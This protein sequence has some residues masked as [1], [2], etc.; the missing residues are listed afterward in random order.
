MLVYR[1]V[2][3]KV[4]TGTDTCIFLWRLCLKRLLCTKLK[5]SHHGQ[6]WHIWAWRNCK[7]MDYATLAE[8]L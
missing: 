4:R 8:L 1:Y 5:S 6:Q 7:L 2:R 3:L